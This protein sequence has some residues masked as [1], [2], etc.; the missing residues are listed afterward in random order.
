MSTADFAGKYSFRG[1]EL[2]VPAYELRRDGSPIRLERQPMDLLIL[3]LERRGQ[4]VSR[5]DIVARLWTK[6][7][8][9][10][11][12]TG[13]NTAIRK[14]RMALGDSP[15]APVFVETVPGKGYR[16]VAAVEGSSAAPPAR[17]PLRL[18]SRLA[19]GLLAVAVI[20]GLATWASFTGRAPTQRVTL[21][22]LPFENLGGDPEREYLAYGLAEDTIATLGQVDPEHLGVIGRTSIMAYKRTTK[23]L[24]DIGHELGAEYL[25]ESSIQGEKGRL[26]VTSKLIRVR[27]QVQIWSAIYDRE[28]L[29]LLGLQRE[30]S[31]AIAE[32][33]SLRLSPDRL[34]A[35]ARRQTRDPEA[36]DLYLRGRNFSNQRTP[37]TNRRAIEYY[38]RAT[39]LDPD[40]ALAWSGLGDAYAASTINSDAPP[41]QMV[42]LAREAIA[43]AVR[44][45]PNLAEAQFALGSFKVLL[46]WDWPGAEVALRRAIELDPGYH[47]AYRSLGHLLSQGGRHGEGTAVMRRA[48]EL[49]PLFAMSHALSSQVAFQARDYRAALDHARQAIVIDPEF[50]VGHVVL[51]QAHEQLGETDLALKAL[52]EGTRFSGGNSKALSFRGH[53]LARLGRTSEARDVLKTLEGVAHD[54]YVPPYALALVH[55]GLGDREAVFDWLNRAYA[56]RDVHLIYLTVDPR[57]DPYRADPRFA[58]LLAR[59]G[60]T[61]AP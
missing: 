6:D 17:S 59:C 38:K 61:K 9:V 30:V 3:L 15:E 49:D 32:Q 44:A 2:D 57:W 7:V 60:F 36:Y 28:P 51:A 39:A 24:A 34:D 10:D 5:A 26:R 48:R 33:I 52:A 35:L 19:L 54:R 22:V 4:L 46:D 40:Y 20:I 58:A 11:V 13:I 8:F 43:Q 1:F 56:A 14:I 27:D 31:T 50:W 12:D 55:A 53:I 41:L 42:P 37:A 16:F 29:S 47:P 21:A 25:V 18:P 45:D 23:S